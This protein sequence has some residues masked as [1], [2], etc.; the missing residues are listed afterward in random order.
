VRREGALTSTVRSVGYSSHTRKVCRPCERDGVY[1]IG[2]MQQVRTVEI[3][4]WVCLPRSF[5]SLWA[6]LTRIRLVARV[7]AYVI[8]QSATHTA[9]HLDTK[10]IRCARTHLEE[11]NPLSQY[12]HT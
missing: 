8:S 1:S 11:V 10:G 4:R 3:C 12:A 7:N 9:R 5:E 2:Y 6:A